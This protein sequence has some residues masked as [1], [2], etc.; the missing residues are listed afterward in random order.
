[1]L[2]GSVMPWIESQQEKGIEIHSCTFKI[3]GLTESK[4]DSLVKPI[5]LS[6]Q[7][8][9]PFAPTFLT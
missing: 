5:A 2:E 9:F 8:S 3:Y 1:M 7:K 4:L 6:E